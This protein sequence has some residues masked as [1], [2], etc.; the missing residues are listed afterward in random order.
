MQGACLEG[1]ESGQ[2][3]PQASDGAGRGKKG[4]SD[5]TDESQARDHPRAKTLLKGP[6]LVGTVNYFPPIIQEWHVLTQ[7]V[8]SQ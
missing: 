5:G 6:L 4:G 1:E 3:E 8:T 7:G 2:R